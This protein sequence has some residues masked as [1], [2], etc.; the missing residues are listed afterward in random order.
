VIDEYGF[1]CAGIDEPE[2]NEPP[3]E[4]EEPNTDT[5]GDGEPDEYQRENDPDSVDKALDK[6]ADAIGEGN[7]KTD[8]SNQHLGNIESAVKSIAADVSSLE[9]MGKNGEL[10]GGGGSS[11]SGEGL[12]N[13]D[14]EDYLGD[15]SDIK[16]NT[17]DTADRLTELK[18]G[19]EG[20]YN[21]DGLGDAPTFSESSDR[22]QLAITSN[23]TIHAVTTVPSI[24]SNNTCPVWTIPATDY[25]QA[26]PIDSH[27]QILDDHRGMLSML[28]IAVWTIAAV[29][30]FL[31]A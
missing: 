9:Q 16:Q 8:Q 25:W 31:R 15:L 29:F 23:P 27:C 11:G 14:G 18:D 10:S 20:G 13:P 5:D 1:I 26:M 12:Q 7:A 21:T 6:V 24:A 28:F 17:K 22:L 30:V 2:D 4:P 3:Q 19:P